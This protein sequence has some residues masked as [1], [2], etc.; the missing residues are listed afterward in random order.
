MVL[1]LLATPMLLPRVAHAD[2]LKFV[3]HRVGTFRGEACGVG[4]FN[5]DGKPDVVAGAYL[6][7]GPEFKPHKI[8]TLKGRWTT[9]A[10]AT[11]G[12]S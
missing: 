3:T 11:A 12:T 8:R 5:N 7:L 1:A 9:K 2:D 6:Y 4:D 10:R